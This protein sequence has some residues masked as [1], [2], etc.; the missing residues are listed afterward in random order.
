MKGGRSSCVAYGMPP[1]SPDST[2]G[3]VMADALTP[4]EQTAILDGNAK[5][6]LATAGS[7]R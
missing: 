1:Q 7:G 3:N 5:Q 4:D 2:E 6:L